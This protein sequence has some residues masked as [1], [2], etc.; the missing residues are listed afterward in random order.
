MSK[1]T[2]SE[3]EVRRIAALAKVRLAGE[4]VQTFQSHF[5]TVLDYVSML[6]VVPAQDV[7]P[8][9]HPG[10]IVASQ[11]SDSPTHGLVQAEALQAAPS[12]HRGAF[13]VPQVKSSG[14]SDG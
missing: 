12:E 5:S 13:A 8:T 6:E 10:D 14:A 3:D 9:A 4:E 2:I 7:E 1:P 11:R